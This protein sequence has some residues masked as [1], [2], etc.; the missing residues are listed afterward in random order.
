MHRRLRPAVVLQKISRGFPG[1][2]VEKRGREV[3]PAAGNN[4]RKKRGSSEP[5]TH[6]ASSLRSAYEEAVREDIPQEFLDLLGKL[7]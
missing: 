3:K 7:S 4:P 5:D 2:A 6:I 1:L